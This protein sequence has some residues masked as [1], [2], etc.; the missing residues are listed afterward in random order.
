[1]PSLSAPLD[2]PHG[3]DDLHRVDQLVDAFA[4]A[5]R[6]RAAADADE[7]RL[8]AR[9]SDLVPRAD[10]AIAGTHT[11]DIGRRSLV[12]ELGAATHLGEYAIV[13]LLSR[14]TDLCA[15]FA[16]GVD[17]LATGEISLRHLEIIHDAGIPIRDDVDRERYVEIALERARTMTPGRLR[18]VVAILAERYLETSLDERAA[19]GA[20]R[21]DVV[22]TDLADGMSEISAIMPAALAHGIDDR[23]SAQARSVIDARDAAGTGAGDDDADR[24]DRTLA[25]VRSDVFT[26]LLLT[27]T[28]DRCLGGD[29]LGE[30][31]GHV[32]VSVPVLTMT[33]SGSEP[34]LLA[35]YGPIDTETAAALAAASP[36]WERV[37]TSPI[38]GAVLATDRYRPG[39]ALRRFLAAR[40]ERCRFPGCRRAVWR[41][42]IDHTVDAAL[43][44]ATM[45][46]NL[47]HLCRRH[48]TLKHAS[49]WTVAQEAPGVLVWTSPSGRRHL[50]PPE[51][52]VR[53]LPDEAL[54]ATRWPDDDP[55]PF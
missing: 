5:R 38:T 4:Q 18:P 24:D 50:D 55:P 34:C 54:R 52:T 39:A 6:A 53:F 26:D 36:L 27:G 7:L 10:G 1:M 29:G 19:A 47:A 49:A 46:E 22:V 45:P 28:P 20:A 33:G 42:D 21:R 14:A 41:C 25:Q 3:V 31:R 9:V 37:L 51:P 30:I 11:S 12:A 32:Q 23:L 13:R 8:L 48:H 43:G 15:R 40:D 16:A 35:G 2:H 17:A 44:G